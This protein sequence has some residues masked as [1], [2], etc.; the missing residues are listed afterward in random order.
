MDCI[1]HIHPL[2]PA[3]AIR[4]SDRKVLHHAQS[5]FGMTSPQKSIRLEVS[6]KQYS[7]MM[8]QDHDTGIGQNR[9]EGY[10]VSYL[11]EFDRKNKCFKCLL[12]I[13]AD[14]PGWIYMRIYRGKRLHNTSIEHIIH[15]VR[16]KLLQLAIVNPEFGC[17]VKNRALEFIE[18]RFFIF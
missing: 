4:L 7:P 6:R 9:F 8:T 15:A 12:Q 18:A 5:P 11:Q 14:E 1:L 16:S 10:K 17:Q 3:N 2:T 13:G